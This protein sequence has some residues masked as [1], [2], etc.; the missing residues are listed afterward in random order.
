MARQ[1][2]VFPL[3]LDLDIRLM[4]LVK[5]GRGRRRADFRKM[6]D[7]FRPPEEDDFLPNGR[8]TVCWV[9]DFGGENGGS[10]VGFHVR[11]EHMA[12]LTEED[13]GVVEHECLCQVLD[14]AVEYDQVHV[15]QLASLGLVCRGVQRIQYRHKDTCLSAT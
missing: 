15:A 7:L 2:G 12:G 5:D 11:W 4:P 14:A 9:L 13:P 8:P 3:P 1:R 6:V 10:M